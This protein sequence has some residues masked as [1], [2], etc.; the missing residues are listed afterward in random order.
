MSHRERALKL[1]YLCALKKALR[2]NFYLAH[3][4]ELLMVEFL[5]NIF[6]ASIRMYSI[7]QHQN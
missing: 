4:F 6:K 1:L 3:S 5:C 2:C 7:K